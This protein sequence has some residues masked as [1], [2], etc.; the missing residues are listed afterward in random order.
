MF[1]VMPGVGQIGSGLRKVLLG[2]GKSAA[3]RWGKSPVSSGLG[4]AVGYIPGC[5]DDGER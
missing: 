4:G 1:G 3:M 5:G 2:G